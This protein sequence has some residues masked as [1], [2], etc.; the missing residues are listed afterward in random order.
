MKAHEDQCEQDN[1]VLAQSADS[2]TSD[3][4]A[5][6]TPQHQHSLAPGI[7]GK[8][9]FSTA[10]KTSLFLGGGSFRFLFFLVFK[11]FK[12]F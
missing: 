9:R 12:G 8:N 2:A 11:S 1:S 7:A 3:S 4:V 6:G 5:A 10:G